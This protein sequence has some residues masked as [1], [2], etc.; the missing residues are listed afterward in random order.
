MNVPVSLVFVIVNVAVYLFYPMQVARFR[1]VLGYWPNAAFPKSWNEKY[2]W[3]KVF[4]RNPIFTEVSDKLKAKELAKRVCPDLLIPRVLWSGVNTHDIPDDVLNRDVMVKANH[5]SSF[6]HVVRAGRC[7]RR[8]LNQLANGWLSR[9]YGRHHAEWSYKG[10]EPRLFVE[11]LLLEPNGDPLA[12]EYKIYTGADGCISMGFTRQLNAAGTVI[13]GILCP[14]GTVGVGEPDRDGLSPDVVFPAEYKTMCIHARR[15]GAMFDHV[16]CDFYLHEG[17]VYF[18]E[19]TVYAQG[20]VVA[21]NNDYVMGNLTNT[22]DLRKSWFLKQPHTGW[23]KVYSDTLK[24]AI[25]GA[26]SG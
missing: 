6:N 15:L 23:Y 3:R 17:N 4:D 13:S 14:D 7:D 16:R 20:G 10:V 1:Y 11:E 22:W 5:G 24:A 12:N 19:L 2:L 26:E 25:T 9:R 18:S 21:M 8:V